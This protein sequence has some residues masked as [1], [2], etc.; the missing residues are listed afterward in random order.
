MI[1][2][3]DMEFLPD[4]S[5]YLSVQENIIESQILDA[6]NGNK[7]DNELIDKYLSVAHY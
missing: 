1:K 2:K 7:V 3:A 6:L 4:N 5:E